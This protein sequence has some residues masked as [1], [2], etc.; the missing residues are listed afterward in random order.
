MPGT[1]PS[2]TSRTAPVGAVKTYQFGWFGD[3]DL[4]ERLIQAVL[5]GKKSATACPAYDP[6]DAD[7]K[8]GDVL[9]IVD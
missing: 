6:E 9:Q 1:D 8:K 4:G 2:S 3:N 7:L 5:Q